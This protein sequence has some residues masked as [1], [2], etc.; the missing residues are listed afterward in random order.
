[1]RDI[2]DAF[3]GRL[4]LDG[5]RYLDILVANKVLSADQ[6]LE[7]KSWGD[8]ANLMLRLNMNIVYGKRE[9]IL[10]P[11]AECNPTLYQKL[12]GKMVE[13]GYAQPL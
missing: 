2:F 4:D 5:L 11:L 1:M 9:A 10:A 7:Y 8:I 6:I 12:M 13:Y 3:D